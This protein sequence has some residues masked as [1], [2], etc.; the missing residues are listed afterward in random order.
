MHL[1]QPRKCRID[2]ANGA[3]IENR[4]LLPEVAGGGLNVT[5]LVFG[6][7]IVR[8]HENSGRPGMGPQFAQQPQ[9]L[10][11]ERDKE[12][13]C[14]RDVAARTLHA[15]DD[16]A[17]DGVGATR[18]DDRYASARRLGRQRGCLTTHCNDDG[19]LSTHEIG[20]EARQSI[21]LTLGPT[22]VQG[23]VLTLDKACFNETLADDR[24]ESRVDS[25]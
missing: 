6:I 2:V 13:A 21:V 10:R 4:D 15:G 7:E 12:R 3:R 1:D 14:A 17:P 8:V 19:H 16:A 5:Q 18:E 22:I 24:D 20:G 9:P 11:L 23:D 25:G